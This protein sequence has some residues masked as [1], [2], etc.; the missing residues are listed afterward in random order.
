MRRRAVAGTMKLGIAGLGVGANTV[1][2]QAGMADFVEL[3]AAA[4]VRPQALKAFAD[5][6]G[7]ATYDSVEGLA[8][9]PDVEVVWVSTP[10][11]LHCQHAV[12]LLEAGKH[13]IVE[14][15]MATKLEDAAKMVETADRVGVKL[16]CGHTASL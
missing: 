6:F 16:M 11:P 13:V 7:S 3:T 2:Q 12:A 1:I 10:N 5:R 9:D 14:K 15:P 8:R 4:D